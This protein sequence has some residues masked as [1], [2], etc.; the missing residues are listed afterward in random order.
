[1]K[2]TAYI[3]ALVSTQADINFCVIPGPRYVLPM[4]YL[5]HLSFC[6]FV[7]LVRLVSRT[8]Q[9]IDVVLSAVC[10]SMLLP[11]HH[12]VRFTSLFPF[13]SLHIPPCPS[14][15]CPS[16]PAATAKYVRAARIPHNCW[17]PV[18]VD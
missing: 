9:S 13:H 15:V 6:V 14:L 11:V 12:E 17:S 5:T 10:D 1:M 8:S 3:S 4:L 2:L 7:D 16:H 18:H